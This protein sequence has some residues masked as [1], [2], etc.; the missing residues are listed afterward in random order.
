MPPAQDPPARRLRPRHYLGYLV[1]CG[2]WS[3]TWLAIR[4]LVTHVPPLRSAA[5]R[6]AIAAMPLLAAVA[7]RRTALPSNRRQWRAVAI[8]GITMMAVPHSL[9]FWAE[10]YI[11]SSITALLFSSLPL[12]VALLTPLMTNHRVP[13]RA[14]FS[15]VIAVG[16][17]GILFSQDLRASP[18][19]FLG[20]V[21]VLGAVFSSAWSAIFAK[22]ETGKLDSLVSTALQLMVASL[23]VGTAS[24]AVERSRPSDWTPSAVLALFFLALAGSAIAFGVYYWLLK[25]MY[26]YQL[27]TISLVVPVVAMVEGAALLQEPIPATMVAAAVVV[28]VAVGSV[29]RSHVAEAE[30]VSIRGQ[31]E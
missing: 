20:G 5:L 21:A 2:I 17:I 6:F 19:L 31:A 1:L 11:T 29:L 9:L 7:I 8:L 28:L 23:L 26:P 16:G 13:R 18:R 10:Q 24:Y 4:V 22:N 30:I 15:M 14:V 25:H 27:S 3:T 12:A